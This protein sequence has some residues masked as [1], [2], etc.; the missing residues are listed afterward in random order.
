MPMPARAKAGTATANVG[1]SPQAMNPTPTSARPSE[2]APFQHG[3]LP[4]PRA[5]QRPPDEAESIDRGQRPE[6]GV[7]R[8]ELVG[9]VRQLGDIE[10][11]REQQHRPRGHD[12][13]PDAHHAGNDPQALSRFA[14]KAGPR[15]RFVLDRRGGPEAQPRQDNGG[16]GERRGVGVEDHLGAPEQEQQGGQRGPHDETEVGDGA[17]QRRRRGQPLRLH[18]AGDGGQ[19][20]G[21]EQAGPG[22]GEQG[23]RDRRGKAVDERYAEKRHA[24]DDVREDQAVPAAT[25]DRRR[26]RTPARAAWPERSRRAG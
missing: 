3:R 22:P 17:V 21:I 20:R 7:A 9:R 11:S 23:E 18:K 12:H 26:P 8:V 25:S 13:R 19:R 10:E 16:H 15:D 2:E 5:G 1:A 24:T 6:A 14:K 4:A